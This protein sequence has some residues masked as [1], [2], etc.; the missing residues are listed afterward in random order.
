MAFLQNKMNSSPG[1]RSPDPNV[2]LDDASLACSVLFYFRGDSTCGGRQ[3]DMKHEN[4]NHWIRL[5]HSSRYKETQRADDEQPHCSIWPLWNV[6]V[7]KI[8]RDA[9]P[10]CTICTHRRTSKRTEI[11]YGRNL[12]DPLANKV[13]M[14]IPHQEVRNGFE[15]D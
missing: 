11:K 7:V 12:L 14:S 8:S 2:F 5:L 13:L 4:A 9:D 3:T 10:R 6:C 1:L 15:R